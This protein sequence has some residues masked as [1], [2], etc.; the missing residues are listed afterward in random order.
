VSLSELQINFR[1]PSDDTLDSPFQKKIPN[2]FVCVSDRTSGS[3]GLVSMDVLSSLT[4]QPAA[5]E[6]MLTLH[7]PF[8]ATGQLFDSYKIAQRHQNAHPLLNAGFSLRVDAS[9]VVQDGMSVWSESQHVSIHT[10]RYCFLENI[11]C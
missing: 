9:N 5:D 1:I 3:R 8:T 4:Y 7:V 2:I 10:D 11:S 6:F